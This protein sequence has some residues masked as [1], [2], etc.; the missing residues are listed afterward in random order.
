[1]PA[2]E[3]EFFCTNLEQLVSQ[4][5][6]SVAASVLELVRKRY[7]KRHSASICDVEGCAVRGP[8]YS[9]NA[10]SS[11]PILEGQ[12]N[13][14]TTGEQVV[15]AAYGHP[16]PRRSHRCLVSRLLKSG[17]FDRGSSIVVKGTGSPELPLTR[18]IATAEAVTSHVYL[19]RAW[20]LTSLSGAAANTSVL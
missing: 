19:V 20:C 6:S 1:M 9:E 5:H 2:D 15:T 16:L 17:I 18:R 7:I 3:P 8:I 4:Y 14:L 13:T 10:N 11:V 12:T